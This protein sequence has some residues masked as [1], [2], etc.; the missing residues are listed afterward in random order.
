M[1]LFLAIFICL[2]S[3][4]YPDDSPKDRAKILDHIFY[5]FPESGTLCQ[6][7]DGFVF[8]DISDDYINQLLQYILP[9]NFESPPFF[10][11]ANGHGAH[12]SVIYSH[13][14]KKN[15][16]K[17]KEAGQSIYFK[18]T[19]CKIVDSNQPQWEATCILKIEAPNLVNLRKKY[20]LAEL[21]YDF[22][23][24]IGVKKRKQAA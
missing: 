21:N 3:L 2:G 7:K 8:V 24:T 16:I 1:K 14:A 11:R 23:I 13:E 19:D 9:E 18:V 6:D 20:G 22:H 4:C 12:I 5:N 15:R 17:I 10:Q